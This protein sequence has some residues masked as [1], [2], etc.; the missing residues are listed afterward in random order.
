MTDL[1]VCA[2]YP[3]TRQRQYDTDFVIRKNNSREV[4]DVAVP[5]DLGN[6]LFRSL[7]SVNGSLLAHGSQ[8]NDI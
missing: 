8:D 5:F 1:L 7:L 4:E 2:A 3:R 6:R